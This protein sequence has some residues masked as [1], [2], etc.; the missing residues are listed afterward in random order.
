MEDCG[1]LSPSFEQPRQVPYDFTDNGDDLELDPTY[2]V[3]EDESRE[4]GEMCE[5][6]ESDRDSCRSGGSSSDSDDEWI[7]SKQK[8]RMLNAEFESV[9]ALY[10]TAH[11]EQNASDSENSENLYALPIVDEDDEVDSMKEKVHF[12]VSS[13]MELKSLVWRVGMRFASPLIFREQVI[14]YAVVAGYS[15][16][17]NKSE[18]NNKLAAKCKKG[19]IWKIYAS[20]DGKRETF[21]VKTVTPDHTC[22]R[23]DFENIQVKSGWLAKEYLEQYRKEPS[24]P[25]NSLITAVMERFGVQ[26]KRF[27]C[28]R[29]KKHAHRMIYGT[30]NEHYNKVGSYLLEL[31]NADPDSTVTLLTEKS[32]I[33]RE[34][35]VFR[36]LY[37]SFPALREGFLR[38]CRPMICLDGC[39]LKT[40]LGGMLLCA[41]GRDG[42]NQMYPIAWAVVEAE[43]NDSWSWF[44]ENLKKDLRGF[45]GENCTISSDQQKV[46]L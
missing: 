13:D 34:P 45:G 3:S 8:L 38:G 20:W 21:V 41:V 42:N 2:V 26:L 1:H 27:T 25:T 37:V 35:E 46:I 4:D 30:I 19:C 11:V 23:Q 24:W 33:P 29:V 32:T 16:R 10:K 39:F 9:G 28:Y 6:K 15:I 31:Q 44:L 14:R 18:K 5:G 22:N 43:N 17:W 7:A 36:R 40:F 12:K